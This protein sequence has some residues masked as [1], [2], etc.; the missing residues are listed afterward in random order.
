MK[1]QKGKLKCKDVEDVVYTDAP[2]K[3]LK[4]LECGNKRFMKDK[5]TNENQ[6]SKQREK[7]NTTQ[8]PF[9]IVLSCADSRVV[10]E[11]VFDTGLG[12]L[13][14]VRVAGN[15]ANTDSIASIEY[16]VAV[17]GC[18]LIVVLGHE[19]CGAV[20][21]AMK[22]DD[23]GYNLNHL[24]AQISPAVKSCGCDA[25]K[26]DVIVE[27]ALHAAEQLV[28]RSE[29]ISNA[30]GTS[31]VKIHTGYYHLESGKVDFDKKSPC[32]KKNDA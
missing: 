10:P 18:K 5:L 21:A 29:I 2:E 19:G 4:R 15:I 24:L 3:I 16:A 23:L 13:F 12:E 32:R 9:A 26:D 8:E 20:G 14:V 7:W 25:P 11:L 1:D 31:G 28:S 22:G 17:L 30:V 6:G 27:N